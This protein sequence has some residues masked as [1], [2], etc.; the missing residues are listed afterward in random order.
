MKIRVII[1]IV[2]AKVSQYNKIYSSIDSKEYQISAVSIEK[3]PISIESEYDEALAVPDI[4]AKII[5][6]ERDGYDAVIVDCF[7]DPGV[8][9]GREIASIPVIGP[10]EASL[11]IAAILG[12]RFSIIAIL[13]GVVSTI[14]NN[15][16]L[17]GL[18]AKLASIR[19]IGFQVFDMHKEEDLLLQA[20]VDTSIKAIEKDGAH[21]IILGCTAM[22]KLAL[23][24]QN[25]LLEKG[26][27]IP[28]IDPSIAALK[29][30]QVLVE[31]K[32]NYSRRTY[33]YPPE[34]IIH[35]YDIART[36]F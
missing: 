32:L 9:A 21:C 31:M 8:R 26:V 5:E 18:E 1:P 27:N 14:H 12:F 20:L 7:A 23:A 33:P 2:T 3:G 13:D 35:G 24:V 34:K 11:H 19:S 15:C 16:L 22:S 10:N 30:A 25:L 29:M 36:N 6:A 17:S 4:L 28:V